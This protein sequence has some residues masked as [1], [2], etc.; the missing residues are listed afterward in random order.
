MRYDFLNDTKNSDRRTTKNEW[1]ERTCFNGIPEYKIYSVFINVFIIITM[2]KQNTKRAIS[3][4]IEGQFL[5][6]FT[7]YVQKCS[8]LSHAVL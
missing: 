6:N 4:G 7:F 8:L 2:H 3:I 5:D 1:A